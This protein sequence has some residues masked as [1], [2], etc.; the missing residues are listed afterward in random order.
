MGSV[1]FKLIYKEVGSWDPPSED[2][3]PIADMTIEKFDQEIQHHRRRLES[4]T[5][6]QRSR[7]VTGS[8]VSPQDGTT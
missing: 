3:L 4:F 8:S 6:M 5:L 2:T 7:A 1:C